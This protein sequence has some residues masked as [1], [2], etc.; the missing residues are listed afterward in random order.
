[1]RELAARLTDWSGP[2][3][4]VALSLVAGESGMLPPEE[5]AV[6]RAIPKRRAEFA[7]G[8]RAAREALKAAGLPQTAILQ[9]DNRAPIW[10]EG[11]IGSIT[12]HEGLA[13]AA[14]AQTRRIKRLGIDLAE[15]N[16]FP[17]KLRKQILKTAAER[18]QTDLEA[19]VSFS[20]KE[21]VFKAFFPDVRAY[22]GFDAV[23]VRPDLHQGTFTA[24]FTR[25]LGPVAAG[26]MHHGK[27]LIDEAC[28]F[29]LLADPA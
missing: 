4:S 9:G 17:E 13:V 6:A 21:S 19:R 26:A 22:F 29:T 12:H 20:A 10:P 3:I 18:A 14:V 1:M 23:E 8:R 27:V 7:A 2:D 5:D 25:D 28:L 16:D 11:A 15:A 24:R